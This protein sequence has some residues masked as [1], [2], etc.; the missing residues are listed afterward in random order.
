ME[1]AK[2]VNMYYNAIMN[3]AKF[4]A[5]S[6]ALSLTTIVSSS[7]RAALLGKG[8]NGCVFDDRENLQCPQDATSIGGKVKLR[9]DIT[10]AVKLSNTSSKDEK[11]GV[12]SKLLSVAEGEENVEINTFFVGVESRCRVKES[13]E[14][15]KKAIEQ[16]NKGKK[17]INGKKD[18]IITFVPLIKDHLKY[19]TVDWKS[20]DAKSIWKI[21]YHL[22]E[23]LKIMKKADVL[24]FDITVDNIVFDPKRILEPKFIDFGQSEYASHWKDDPSAHKILTSD[25]SSL[26]AIISNESFLNIPSYAEAYKTVAPHVIK[27]NRKIKKGV[28]EFSSQG[29]MDS[30]Y[31]A[32]NN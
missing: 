21:W 10:Y 29:I 11:E 17:I 19:D 4:I 2:D 7:A 32:I 24:H 9:S 23:G 8:G 30:L 5:L 3:I 12:I 27:L 13:N 25:I 18:I 14:S 16:C 20:L 26:I 15:I 31:E 28:S 6:A 1:N 22:F